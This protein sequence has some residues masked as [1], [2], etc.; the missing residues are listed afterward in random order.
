MHIDIRTL[1]NGSEIEGDLCIIGAGAAGISMALEWANSTKRVILLEGGGFNVEAEM[2]NLYKGESIGQRYYPLNSARLHFFGGTTGHWAGWCAPYDPIDF[3]KRDWVE[4]SGWP[5]SYNDLDPYYKKAYKLV[6]L[7]TPD[8]DT[9]YW[10]RQAPNMVLLPLDKNKVWT[11]MWQFSPPTRFGTKYREDILK[12]KSV[13]LYTYANLT[14]IETNPEVSN[15]KKI[16]VQSLDGKKYYVK[17]KAFVM[18]CGAIQNARMLL[19]SNKQAPKGLGNDNDLVGR[20][21]MEHLEVK[22]AD[23]VMASER[24]MSMYLLDFA[25]IRARGELALSEQWQQEH[26]VLNGT[27]SMTPKTIAENEKAAI[28]WFPDDAAASIERMEKWDKAKADTTTIKYKPA[29]LKVF[30][31]FTRMEQSPNP[32]SRVF[33]NQEKDEMGIPR[34]TLDWKLTSFE[35]DSIR[36]LYELIGQEAGRTRVGRVKIM[37][38]LLDNDTSWP[39]FL[40]A[41]WH[42]MGTTKMN[43]N[44]KEGVVDANCKVHGIDNLYIASTGCYSTAGAANPTLTLLALTLRLSDHLKEKLG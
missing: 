36:K 27:T 42:H 15:V 38:W 29:D 21:F 32:N 10:Q 4:H 7:P 14:N 30:E 39:E 41:G 22:S 19:A 26:H 24:E 6:E 34:I 20:Y 17:A 5:I 13:H 8:F 43:E 18:A 1:Q 11:K 33:L 23:L 2:Q 12:A 3:K 9:S 37:D 40:S 25:R 28:D 31:L 16:Q 35:K 44:P